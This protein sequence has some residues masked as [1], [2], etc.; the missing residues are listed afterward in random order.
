MRSV[1][2]E[3]AEELLEATP[4]RSNWTVL[5]LSLAA[6]LLDCN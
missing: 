4:K 3:E 5:G 1:Q 2:M 6:L